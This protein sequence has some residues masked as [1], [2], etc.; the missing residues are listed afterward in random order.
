MI[1]ELSGGSVSL[2][3]DQAKEIYESGWYGNQEGERL[4]LSL[5]EAAFLLER[6]KIGISGTD[7]EKF[8]QH[9]SEK[10]PHFIAR[11]AVYKDLRERGLPIREGFKGCDFRVYERGANAEKPGKV[12]WI[13]FA[14]AEDYPCVFERLGNAIELA[15]NIRAVAIW[16]VVDNDTDVTF[17]II[18]SVE[19]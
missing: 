1:G 7:L 8:L 4:V 6:G 3:I 9:C 10:D 17:Y 14:E 18:N 13:I 11:Y 12:K 15:K 2:P 16:A 19:P 5:V